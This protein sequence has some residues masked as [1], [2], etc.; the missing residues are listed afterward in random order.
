MRSVLR[1]NQQHEGTT[2]QDFLLCHQSLCPSRMRAAGLRL[3]WGPK[4]FTKEA[5][6]NQRAQ[7]TSGKA[8]SL[9]PLLINQ[10]LAATLLIASRWSWRQSA[11]WKRLDC[12]SKWQFAFGHSSGSCQICMVTFRKDNDPASKCKSLSTL[13]GA[14]CTKTVI[15]EEPAAKSPNAIIFW[16]HKCSSII[17]FVFPLCLARNRHSH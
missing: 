7:E 13:S 10:D 9:V 4:S 11:P 5:V 1:D 8:A 17:A 14:C 2:S 16:F 15:R 3:T 12:F 6:R